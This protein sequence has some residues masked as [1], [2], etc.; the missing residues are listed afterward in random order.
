MTSTVGHHGVDGDS[1]PSRDFGAATTTHT[2]HIGNKYLVSPLEYVK[3]KYR[4]FGIDK[5]SKTAASLAVSISEV[6]H[7]KTLQVLGASV[8]APPSSQESAAKS[9]VLDVK[10]KGDFK[11]SSQP[12]VTT[13]GALLDLGAPD[14]LEQA[15][16][17]K[18][19]SKGK[20]GRLNYSSTPQAR[21]QGRRQPKPEI[22]AFGIEWW[23]GVSMYP[24]MAARQQCR[25]CQEDTRKFAATSRKDR[26]SFRALCVR[27][28]LWFDWFKAKRD[29][30]D[31]V[32]D[33]EDAS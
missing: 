10:G 28:C 22:D 15:R 8:A 29:A 30:M 18:G 24:E 3:L 23:N 11:A 12:A 4:E 21:S 25:F 16:R 31:S 2:H 5:T 9:A 26:E 27:G 17:G 33:D 13:S 14:R 6:T 19:D 1:S 7:D 32:D 20:P